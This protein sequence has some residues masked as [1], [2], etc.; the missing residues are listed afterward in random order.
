[1]I[2]DPDGPRLL[3]IAAPAD[4]EDA[5]RS[6]ALRAQRFTL[7]QRILADGAWSIDLIDVEPLLDPNTTVLHIL[8]SLDLNLATLRAEFRSRSDFDVLFEPAGSSLGLARGTAVAPGI[9]PRFQRRSG[10][11]ETVIARM[12]VVERLPLP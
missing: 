8:G 10:G 7:C 11:A 2:H 1:M 3:R 12:V 6:E 5:R 4:L 9:L